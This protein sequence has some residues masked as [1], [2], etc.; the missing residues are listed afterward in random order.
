MMQVR[1]VLRT[2]R[3]IEAMPAIV[4]FSSLARIRRP[5]S[6]RKRRWLRSKTCSARSA[7]P[8]RNARPMPDSLGPAG[9]ARLT[10]AATW[11]P[12]SSQPPP[13]QPSCPLSA[14]AFPS[15]RCRSCATS[16]MASGPSPARRR[17]RSAAGRPS[18]RLRSHPAGG[19][20][21]RARI[22]INISP[23]ISSA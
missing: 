13:L 17:R 3:R 12:A 6:L 11:T 19:A 8:V 23:T 2:Q 4:H 14:S 1:D 10:F 18:G 9:L 21:P 20:W 5:V 15:G 16:S 22:R 7:T